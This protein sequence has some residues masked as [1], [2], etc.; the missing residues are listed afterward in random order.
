MENNVSQ[1]FIEETFSKYGKLV[2]VV[3]PMKKSYAFVIYEDTAST[4]LAIQNLQSQIITENQTPI[5]Y[6]LFPVDRRNT[7]YILYE[8]IIISWI[9]PY[10][11][12]K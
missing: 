4:K 10:I 11:L 7:I 5:V 3:M 12:N 6:Y 2:D 9:L 1:T 8:K